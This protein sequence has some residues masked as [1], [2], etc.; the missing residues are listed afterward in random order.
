MQQLPVLLVR[1][2]KENSIGARRL[3]RKCRD[4]LPDA[5]QVVWQTYQQEGVLEQQDGYDV[6]WPAFLKW[7]DDDAIERFVLLA[8]NFPTAK[9]YALA[10]QLSEIE[11]WSAALCAYSLIPAESEEAAEAVFWQNLGVCFYE[12]GEQDTAQECFARALSL[13]PANP[14]VRAYQKWSR[15]GHE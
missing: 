4:M 15:E 2:E 10:R 3:A 7:A 1:L 12:L 8:R 14:A 13:D 9:I 5:M 6:F 11:R